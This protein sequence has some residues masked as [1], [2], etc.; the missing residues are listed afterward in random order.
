[1]GILVWILAILALQFAEVSYKVWYRTKRSRLYV[2]EVEI[3]LPRWPRPWFFLIDLALMCERSTVFL[4]PVDVF[5]V[6]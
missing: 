1:M 3:Q 2:K 4:H 5:S 6:S